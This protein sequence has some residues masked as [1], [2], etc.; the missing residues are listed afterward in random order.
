M[1]TKHK[2]IPLK[3]RKRTHS[4]NIT[5]NDV[6]SK[7]DQFENYPFDEGI[8]NIEKGSEWLPKC[9]RQLMISAVKC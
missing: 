7:N 1:L 8:V 5:L 3:S 2:K 9:L 4:A 6:R